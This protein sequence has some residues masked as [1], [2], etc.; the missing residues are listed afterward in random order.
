M[1]QALPLLITA[2]LVITAACSQSSEK[3][4]S[5][6]TA[7]NSRSRSLDYVQPIS[8]LSAAGDTISTIE[9]AIADDDEERSQGLMDVNELPADK[10]MLFIF[11]ENKPRSFWMANTPLSL[12]II[13]VN[14]DKTIVRIHHSTQPFSEKNLASQQ[15]ARYVI[16]TN[17]GYC[18]SHDIQEGM[19]VDF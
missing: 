14:A 7:D 5:E 11:D 6:S 16:E 3:Q 2:L 18:V 10:G 4:N 13:F 9:A 19:K 12:D 8:F 1:K 15:P 17:A